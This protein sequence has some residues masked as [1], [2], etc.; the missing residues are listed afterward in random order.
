[1]AASRVERRS[2]I[3][4]QTYITLQRGRQAKCVAL[5]VAQLTGEW[6]RKMAK[7]GECRIL[8]A[9]EIDQNRSFRNRQVAS[10]TLALGSSFSSANR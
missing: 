4:R 10:S 9:N 2:F 6:G 3:H 8:K 5:C 7:G 1:L